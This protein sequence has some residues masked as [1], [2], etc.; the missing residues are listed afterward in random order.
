[1]PDAD[2]PLLERRTIPRHEPRRGPPRGRRARPCRLSARCSST[3]RRGTRSA[4]LTGA[5]RRTPSAGSPPSSS[6]A[7]AT[8]PIRRPRSSSSTAS[9]AEATSA[10]RSLRA[11]RSG[12]KRFGAAP[13]PG[14]DSC[15]LDVTL[16]RTDGFDVNVATQTV[17]RPRG[18]P[19]RG[20]H[21]HRRNAGPLPGGSRRRDVADRDGLQ[22]RV[23]SLTQAALL[24]NPSLDQSRVLTRRP[25]SSSTLPIRW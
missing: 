4:R 21:R 24:T 13:M 2:S 6:S 14:S 20:Q 22:L 16:I 9:A 11:H 3:G 18:V 17:H 23:A 19:V 10:Q 1:M 5:T 8:C 12:W 7:T 25:G 15:E